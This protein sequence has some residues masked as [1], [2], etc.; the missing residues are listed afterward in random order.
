MV[1]MLQVVVSKN[2][3]L[4]MIYVHKVYWKMFS[5]SLRVREGRIGKSVRGRRSQVTILSL[6]RPCGALKLG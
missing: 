5:G 6:A 2:E 4:R 3:T 1:K